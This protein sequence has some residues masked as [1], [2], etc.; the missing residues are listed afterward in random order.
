MHSLPSIMFSTWVW[1]LGLFSLSAPAAGAAVAAHR[2]KTM[3]AGSTLYA[4]GP[5][6]SALPVF[7]ADGE[8]QIHITSLTLEQR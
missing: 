2:F 1:A 3:P 6:I 4:F 5:N 8:C 7:Y